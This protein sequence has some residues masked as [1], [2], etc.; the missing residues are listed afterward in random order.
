MESVDETESNVYEVKTA[1]RVQ[2]WL[3]SL[4]YFLSYF[5]L[6]IYFYTLSLCA[7]WLGNHMEF[8]ETL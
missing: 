3:L 6:V 2:K 7:P 5:P 4:S 8:I 1:C